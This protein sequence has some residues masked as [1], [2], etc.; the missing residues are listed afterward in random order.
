MQRILNS[1]TLDQLYT[2]TMCVGSQGVGSKHSHY[3]AESRMCVKPKLV[4][5]SKLE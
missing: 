4:L 1:Y 3:P 5:L 2:E